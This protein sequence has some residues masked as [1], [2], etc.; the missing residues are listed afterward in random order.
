MKYLAIFLQS[1]FRW[2]LNIISDGVCTKENI[3]SNPAV[4]TSKLSQSAAYLW[5][6]EGLPMRTTP[7]FL[8]IKSDGSV[9]DISRFSGYSPTITEYPT[10]PDSNIEARYTA[11]MITKDM[12]LYGYNWNSGILTFELYFH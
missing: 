9:E 2:P 8:M 1:N 10:N 5:V 6:K 4:N 11:F 3:F 12:K 7:H